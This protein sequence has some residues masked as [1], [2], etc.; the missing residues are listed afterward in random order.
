MNSP[1]DNNSGTEVSG[2]AYAREAATFSAPVG[3][4]T[5]NSVDITFTQATASWGT[6]THFGILDASSGGN[7]LYHGALTTAKTVDNG[8]IFKFTSGNLSVTLQ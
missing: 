6:V 1:N 5:S 3:G 8:D 7:L 4:V 2:G